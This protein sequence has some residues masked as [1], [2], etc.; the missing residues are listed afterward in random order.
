MVKSNILFVWKR[1]FQ[2]RNQVILWRIQLLKHLIIRF[3][4]AYEWSC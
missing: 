3:Y 2:K 4:Q 1:S